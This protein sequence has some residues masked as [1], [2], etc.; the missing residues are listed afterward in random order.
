LNIGN[1][2]NGMKKHYVY[3]RSLTRC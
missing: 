1:I 2:V 3:N